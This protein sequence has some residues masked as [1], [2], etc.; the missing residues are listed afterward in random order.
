MVNIR[1]QLSI[2]LANRPGTLAS[3]CESLREK[4]VNILAMTVSDTVDHAVVRMIVDKPGPA[5]HQLEGQGLLVVENDVLVVR[6]ENKPGALAE[7][8]GQL[9]EHEVNIEYAY[10]TGM[11]SQQKGLM[12]FRTA[13]PERARELLEAD[14]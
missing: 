3:V 6:L 11:P 1:K 7:L 2:F 10:C 9:A 12:V 5:V 4:E 14:N 8:A 13:D